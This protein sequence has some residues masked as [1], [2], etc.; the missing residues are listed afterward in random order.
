MKIFLVRHGEAKSEVEDPERGLTEKGFSDVEKVACFAGRAGSEV[1]KIIHSG[2]KR[3]EETAEVFAK[4]LNP[5][6]GVAVAEGLAPMDE[7][8]VW[9]GR[10]V[11]GDTT[12]GGLMV[13]GHLPH[14]ARLAGLLTCGTNGKTVTD[15]KAGSA[16]CLEWN[17]D[18]GWS[19]LWMVSPGSLGD[20]A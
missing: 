1:R 13:V 3:A 5:K 15:F 12:F 16:A 18:K 14:L 8:G 9:A 6:E 2:K 4:H 19:V 20:T 7:P 17:E 10:L 11:E